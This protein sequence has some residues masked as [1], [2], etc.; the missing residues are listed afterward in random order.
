MVPCLFECCFKAACVWTS[1]ALLH[2]RWLGHSVCSHGAVRTRIAGPTHPGEHI[3]GGLC[4]SL[5]VCV[6]F[7][8]GSCWVIKVTRCRLAYFVWN[9]LLSAVV[10]RTF[11]FV[12]L[13]ACGHLC[14]CAWLLVAAISGT[15]TVRQRTECFCLGLT[16]NP[17]LEIQPENVRLR[18]AAKSGTDCVSG[19]LFGESSESLFLCP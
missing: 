11:V 8:P 17:R 2:F 7:L 3:L 1:V 16:F 4:V 12:C 18:V 13:A 9:G 10:H 19:A 6:W 15:W 14:L 5:F